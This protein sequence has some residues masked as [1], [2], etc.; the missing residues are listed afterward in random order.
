MIKV[1]IIGAGNIAELVNALNNDQVK[2]ARI[3]KQVNETG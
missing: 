2:T 1:G 3:L